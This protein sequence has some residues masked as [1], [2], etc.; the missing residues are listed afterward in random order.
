MVVVRVTYH[1]PRVIDLGEYSTPIY[2]EPVGGSHVRNVTFRADGCRARDI[3]DRDIN[4]AF[5]G[6]AVPGERA[7]DAFH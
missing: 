3:L 5:R 4:M 7:P 6:V 1:E 2:C